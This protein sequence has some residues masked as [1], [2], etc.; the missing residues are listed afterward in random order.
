MQLVLTIVVI[1]PPPSAAVFAW[2]TARAAQISTKNATIESSTRTENLSE[3]SAFVGAAAF[4]TTTPTIAAHTDAAPQLR[5][6]SATNA[7]ATAITTNPKTPL[8]QKLLPSFSNVK[9]PV[10]ANATAVPAAEPDHFTTKEFKVPFTWNPGVTHQF[11][12]LLS[13]SKSPVGVKGGSDN[14]V[15][16][17]GHLQKGHGHHAAHFNHLPHHQTSHGWHVEHSVA[18]DISESSYDEVNREQLAVFQQDQQYENVGDAGGLKTKWHHWMK[19]PATLWQKVQKF[20]IDRAGAGPL[21]GTGQY[22]H[23]HKHSDAHH[24]DE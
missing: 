3:L 10:T 20:G 14:A 16:S 5:Q 21:Y 6:S 8:W 15:T 1:L 9:S 12:A 7:T 19:S 18:G 23:K 22:T 13:F 4:I 2:P 11:H 17:L 24:W